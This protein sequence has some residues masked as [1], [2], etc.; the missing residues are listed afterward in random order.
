MYDLHIRLKTVFMLIMQFQLLTK[1]KMVTLKML[2]CL[3]TFIFDILCVLL[4]NV[5][6]STFMNRI[7]FM[8]NCRQLSFS[9]SIFRNTVRMLKCFDPDHPEFC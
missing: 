5:G 9:P 3:K 6:I 2:S 4:I 7:N 1:G 8:L